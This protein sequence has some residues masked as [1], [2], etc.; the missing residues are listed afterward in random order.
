MRASGY[1]FREGRPLT[2]AIDLPIT[3]SSL[4]P[5]GAEINGASKQE[6]AQRRCQHSTDKV[7]ANSVLR[8]RAATSDKETD[9][10]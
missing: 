9:G 6:N 5:R 8:M 3:H 7:L 1:E 2:G 10:G 4:G